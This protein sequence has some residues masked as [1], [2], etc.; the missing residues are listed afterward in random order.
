MTVNN[1]WVI[2]NYLKQTIRTKRL[3]R[4]NVDVCSSHGYSRGLTDDAKRKEELTYYT[5]A[6]EPLSLNLECVFSTA[7]AGCKPCNLTISTNPTCS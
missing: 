7:A 4:T 2:S 5:E 1:K 6:Q 3:D